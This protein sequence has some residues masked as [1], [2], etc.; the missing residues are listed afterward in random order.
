MKK[1]LLIFT[2][3]GGRFA[4]Q[5]IN[6]GHLIAFIEENKNDFNLIDIA[7]WRYASF[8]KYFQQNKSCYYP[9]NHN[10]LIIIR[11]L[12]SLIK[13]QN[14]WDEHH[15]LKKLIKCFHRIAE[16]LPNYQSIIDKDNANVI[17]DLKGKFIG[18]INL[19]DEKITTVFKSQKVTFLAGWSIRSW[20]LFEKHQEKIKQTLAI[21]DKYKLKAV[22]FIN[23]KRKK[24]NYLIG[25]LI[26]QD[27][28]R[29][30]ANGK[31]FFETSKYV[32][33]MKQVCDLFKEKDIAFIVTSDE[34]QDTRDFIGLNV[35]F[36]TGVAIGKGHFI[37]NFVELSFCDI[38]MTPPSTFSVLAAFMENKPLIPLYNYFQ[39]IN[40]KDILYN[41]LFDS[42]KHTDMSV[43]VN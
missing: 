7:F 10:Q 12:N 29:Y 30:W 36:A 35:Y 40:E 18:D 41:H 32:E 14:G 27:D 1:H 11:V 17:R 3:G 26:R 33:W 43:S 8:L 6:F 9:S 25:V 23:D 2:H 38:I 15:V 34:K 5:L 31:Y 24:H 16:L 39:E 21:D 4:N 13:K 19:N 22:D 28:Y 42:Y 37:E 20:E